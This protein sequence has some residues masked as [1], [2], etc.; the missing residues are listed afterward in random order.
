MSG[1]DHRTSKEHNCSEVMDLILV[2][3][4]EK[5]PLLKMQMTAGLLRAVV[6]WKGGK[7]NWVCY[8]QS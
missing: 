6:S 1:P 5:T 4:I 7:K 8:S 3:Q 2:D